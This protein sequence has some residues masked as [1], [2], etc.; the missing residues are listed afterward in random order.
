[1]EVNLNVTI[2]AGWTDLLYTH[3]TYSRPTNQ[4]H[5][6]AQQGTSLFNAAQTLSSSSPITI[7]AFWWWNWISR[8]AG[9]LSSHFPELT[10][11]DAPSY[12][13]SFSH[14]N[15][16]DH[17]SLFAYA[18][19]FRGCIHDNPHLNRRDIIPT[20]IHNYI[21]GNIHT[22]I[23]AYTWWHEFFLCTLNTPTY[24]TDARTLYTHYTT[25]TCKHVNTHARAHT[26]CTRT[27]T[28][29]T[30]THTT[31]MRTHTKRTHT[32]S[33]TQS[34]HTLTLN[35]THTHTHIYTKSTA[36]VQNILPSECQQWDTCSVFTT[37]W[38]F[39]SSAGNFSWGGL[40]THKRTVQKGLRNRTLHTDY[41][42]TL[43]DKD[44]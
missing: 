15:A 21:I 39:N 6:Q 9:T 2:I 19:C 31:R 4:A 14:G 36:I 20:S 26:P 23:R 3:T 29:H 1:M 13:T 24:Y 34:T 43:W 16:L 42:T 35:H 7:L 25:H 30:H 28:M 8:S 10:N 32:H 27:H 11:I 22:E 5:Y 37:T 41:S 18:Q 40:V 38:P 33:H 17:V 12:W 44:S